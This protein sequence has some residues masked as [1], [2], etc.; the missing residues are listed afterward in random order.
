MLR[1]RVASAS[2]RRFAWLVEHFEGV[3]DV[4]IFATPLLFDEPVAKVGIP[5]CQQTADTCLAKAEAAA[6]EVAITR[7]DRKST[8]LNSSH[9]V[10]SYAVFCLKKKRYISSYY[11]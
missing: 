1:V 7:S 4:D 10:I 11:T 8:R 3:E 2:E 6:S 9:V 5:V